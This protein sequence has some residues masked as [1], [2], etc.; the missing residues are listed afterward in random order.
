LSDFLPNTA[1]EYLITPIMPNPHNT[2][3]P[4]NIKKC[5]ILLKF[6]FVVIILIKMAIRYSQPIGQLTP[7]KP[8]KAKGQSIV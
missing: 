2:I 6:S 8:K 5:S 3:C 7:N 1:I 4:I